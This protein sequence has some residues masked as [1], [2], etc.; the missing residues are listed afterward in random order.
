MVRMRSIVDREGSKGVV[1]FH[2]AVESGRLARGAAGMGGE[3]ENCAAL[4][5]RRWQFAR[6]TLK[7]ELPRFRYR[8]YS[9]C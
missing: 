4:A 9:R 8:A 1:K 3:C 5:K 6:R 2:V 7:S